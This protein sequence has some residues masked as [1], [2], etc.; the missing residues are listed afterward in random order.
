MQLLT[1]IASCLDST[2]LAIAA[3][4]YACSLQSH[5]EK[6]PSCSKQSPRMLL[7][8]GIGI[9]DMKSCQLPNI[10]SCGMSQQPNAFE[11]MGAGEGS[12]KRRLDHATVLANVFNSQYGV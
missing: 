3:L 9:A 10:L 2:E 8:R 4:K 1:A 11:S 7:A 6:G 12:A 5:L